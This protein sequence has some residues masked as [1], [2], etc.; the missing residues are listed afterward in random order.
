MPLDPLP[1]MRAGALSREYQPVLADLLRMVPQVAPE[2]T[3]TGD[4]DFGVV[5]LQ[6]ASYLADHLHYR[7]DAV[8]RDVVPTRSPH[9]EVVREFAE[10]LGYMARRPTP[11]E[12]DVTLTVDAPLEEDLPIPRRLAVEGDGPRGRVTFEVSEQVILRAG[13]TSVEAHVVEGVSVVSARVGVATGSYLER[14]QVPD[15]G[16][17]FNWDDADLEVTVDGEVA[18][19]FRYPALLTPSTLGYWVRLGTS[20]LLELR[21]GDGTYGRTLTPGAEVRCTYRVGGGTRGNVK[22]GGLSRVPGTLRLSDGTP[23]T[24]GV[25]QTQA[26]A[27]GFDAEGVDQI[28]AQAPANFRAQERAVTR[29]DYEVLALRVPGVYQARVTASGVNGVNVAIVPAGLQSGTRVSRAMIERVT[30]VV[31]PLR[32]VTD[33]VYVGA[34]RLV[35]VDVTLDVRARRGSRNGTV[36]EAVRERLTGS[37]GLLTEG[38]NRIGDTLWLSDLVGALEQVSGVDNLD[39]SRYCRRPE[40]V[41]DSATGDAAL[42]G[43]V[44][45]MET[46]TPATW[47]VE[48][49]TSDT[50]TVSGEDGVL[51]AVGT[52][53]SAYTVPGQVV[54]TISPGVSDMAEGDRGR[55][56]VGRLVGNVTLAADEFPVFDPRSVKIRVS[57]GIGA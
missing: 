42:H 24:L 6:L 53:G 48:M 18:Q 40:L 51:E 57:G 33:C 26:V 9:A 43:G 56:T 36:L 10:W 25:T 35:T 30:R 16:C 11:A 20:G 52:L 29:S 37:S 17:I 7:A 22:I 44:T 27:P 28:R 47:Q 14:F 21:F 5:L 45:L 32:M 50:F 13:L 3:Y 15:A 49:L 4:D 31:D 19:H 23:V 38:V 1:S 8:M 34:A 46:T 41:W 54:F 12:V 55:I 2:W 39:V